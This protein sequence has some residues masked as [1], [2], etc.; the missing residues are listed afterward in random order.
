MKYRLSA[1]PGETRHIP[2][3]RLSRIVFIRSSTMPIHIKSKKLCRDCGRFFSGGDFETFGRWKMS[4]DVRESFFVFSTH[5]RMLLETLGRKTH[6]LSG[7]TEREC[8]AAGLLFLAAPR[9]ARLRKSNDLPE[10]TARAERARGG[11]GG[12]KPNESPAAEQS[13]LYIQLARFTAFICELPTVSR[14]ENATSL[15]HGSKKNTRTHI[16]VLN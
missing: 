3:D 16:Q 4:L 10:S 2:D 8:G 15:S 13:T 6:R 11:F 12:E 7:A 5:V 14:K 9:C 1:A